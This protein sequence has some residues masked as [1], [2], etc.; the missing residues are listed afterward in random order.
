M[1]ILLF[2][3]LITTTFLSCKKNTDPLPLNGTYSGQFIHGTKGYTTNKVVEVNFNRS[4]YV[5]TKGSGTFLVQQNNII[6]FSDKNMWAANFDWNTILN[7]EYSYE[8]KSDSLI[9]T[10]LFWYS[11]RAELAYGIAVVS[12]YRLKLNP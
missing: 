5:A 2:L 12:Q 6:N 11:G 3:A 4:N 7:G 8:I 1:K 9:L 10:K